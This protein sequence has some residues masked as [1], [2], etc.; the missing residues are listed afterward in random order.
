MTK[1]QQF[2]FFASSYTPL[3]IRIALAIE[4]Q[5]STAVIVAE[6]QPSE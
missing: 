3:L 4:A 6:A 5:K 2:S 1:Q